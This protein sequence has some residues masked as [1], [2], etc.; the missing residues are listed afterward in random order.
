MSCS[1]PAAWQMNVV[2]MGRLL[3][4]VEREHQAVR[5]QIAALNRMRRDE[6]LNAGE[7]MRTLEEY[8]L[9]NFRSEQYIIKFTYNRKSTRADIIFFC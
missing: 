1:G 7:Q 8:A 3:A 6:Q 2:L 4:S 5:A 9:L